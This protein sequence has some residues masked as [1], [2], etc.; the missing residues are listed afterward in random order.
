MRT[1]DDLQSVRAQ[2]TSVHERESV[3]PGAEPL[4]DPVLLAALV[5]GLVSG[6][7][8]PDPGLRLRCAIVLEKVTRSRADL[9]V[10]HKSTLLTAV[11]TA[12]HPDVQWQ[13]A[14]LVPRLGL[15]GAERREALALLVRLF[16][17]SPI[18]MVQASALQAVVELARDHPEHEG[19][20]VGCLERA[21][22]SSSASVRS[23]AWRLMA[24]GSAP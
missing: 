12:D 23:R 1:P 6:L 11:S 7:V 13:L 21:L 24:R 15:E 14:R 18:G 9:L 5:A 19:L 3:P 10:P 4:R 8:G 16:D 2:A 17:E 22:G 20:A